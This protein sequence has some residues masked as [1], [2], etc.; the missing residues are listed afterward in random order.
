MDWQV[1]H[2]LTHIVGSILHREELLLLFQLHDHC[3]CK[4]TGSGVGAGMYV[5]AARSVTHD[6]E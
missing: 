4:P 2:S 6:K 1:L 5:G 3:A